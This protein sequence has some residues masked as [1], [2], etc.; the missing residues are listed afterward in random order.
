MILILAS[1]EVGDG[2]DIIRK[3]ESKL[4]TSRRFVTEGEGQF[5]CE[6]NI[7][8]CGGFTGRITRID[9]NS[10]G[11]NEEELRFPCPLLFRIREATVEF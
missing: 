3:L 4:V 11:L 6:D 8:D 1:G 7:K 2:M 10:V 5:S 9:G